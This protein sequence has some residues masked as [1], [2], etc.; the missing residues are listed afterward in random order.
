MLLGWAPGR[1]CCWG[2]RGCI[3][4][5]RGS[6]VHCSGWTCLWRPTCCHLDHGST[7]GR[8]GTHSWIFISMAQCKTAVTPLLMHWRYRSLALNHRY[9]D[10][11]VPRHAWLHSSLKQMFNFVAWLHIILAAS[12]SLYS[13]HSKLVILL[14][15]FF[16]QGLPHSSPMWP[17]YRTCLVS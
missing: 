10:L 11:L 8:Q 3:H 15:N 14:W 16:S 17:R 6:G 12:Y 1:G 4:G 9:D 5:S 2:C 13:C 7:Y